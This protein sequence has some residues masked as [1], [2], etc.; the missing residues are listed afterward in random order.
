MVCGTFLDQG[1]NPFLLHWQADSATL[2]EEGEEGDA[3]HSTSVD[4]MDANTT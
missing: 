2:P 4:L 3:A 1:S